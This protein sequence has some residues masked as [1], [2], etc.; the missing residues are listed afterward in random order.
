MLRCRVVDNRQ[1]GRRGCSPMVYTISHYFFP[2]SPRVGHGCFPVSTR[3]LKGVPTDFHL[4]LFIFW[5]AARLSF[6][7]LSRDHISAAICSP[8]DN[9]SWS[10]A[11][12]SRYAKLNRYH[13]PL[14]RCP[15]TR[16][17]RRRTHSR[18]TSGVLPNNFAGTS[19]ST[20]AGCQGKVPDDDS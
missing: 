8:R 4:S 9:H 10:S 20:I 5:L 1:K 14:R 6:F 15:S 13:W 3:V 11:H 18:M 2:L 7:S 17:C 19:I 12:S 16:R